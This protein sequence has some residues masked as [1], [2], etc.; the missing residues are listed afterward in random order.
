MSSVLESRLLQARSESGVHRQMNRQRRQKPP[1][2][3]A[4]S[5]TESNKL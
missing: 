4:L 2:N 1:A 3:L 5:S